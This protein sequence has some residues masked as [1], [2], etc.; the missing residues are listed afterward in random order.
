MP[1]CA[2][3]C[4]KNGRGLQ[5]LNV[6]VFLGVGLCVGL[7]AAA[8]PTSCIVM[9]EIEASVIE[10]DIAI[11]VALRDAR[12]VHINLDRGC[13]QLAFHQRFTYRATRGRLCA[14]EDFIISRSGDFCRIESLEISD[15]SDMDTH[16]I[17]P[18]RPTP[19]QN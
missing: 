5:A 13:P 11:R 10:S 15:A 12:V 17:A 9:S 6:G 2:A 14:A 4:E 3:I 19:D 18:A 7:T 1:N 16:E 8:Q